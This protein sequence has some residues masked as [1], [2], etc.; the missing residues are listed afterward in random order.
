MKLDKYC[1]KSTIEETQCPVCGY[2][3]D[4][5]DWAWEILGDSGDV[6]NCGFCSR[7]C[8]KSGQMVYEVER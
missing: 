2:P 8:A 1:I 6:I 7:Q 3:S 4:I 5:G